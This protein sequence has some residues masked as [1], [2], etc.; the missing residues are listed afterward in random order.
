MSIACLALTML[1]CSKD[2]NKTTLPTITDIAVDNPDFSILV[3]ALTRTN[4]AGTLDD[5]S[6]QF[7]VFAPTNAAFNTFF[8]SLGSGVN[9]NNVNVDVLKAVL[10]NHV[11][12]AEVKAAQ[13]PTAG[14]A[15]TLSPFNATVTNSPGISMFLQK[16]GTNVFINGGTATTGVKVTTADVDA[17]NGVI[18]IVNAVIAIPTI[19]DHVVANPE[20]ETLQTVVTSAPQSAVLNLLAGLTASAPATLFAPNNAAFATALGAGGFANGATDAQVTKVLQYHAS[21]AGNVRSTNLTNNMAI[22]TLTNPA[23]STTA[24]LGNGTVDIRDSANNLARVNQ[25]DIQCSNGVIHGINR[26]LQPVFN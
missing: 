23:Q 6:K 15:T 17:S 13:V 1:A 10:L 14:Y 9:V 16:Q 2:D 19:V 21:A 24:I 11:L 22:P 25:A 20:F 4:L 3:E 8:G 12:G 5:N 7:T 26:V 18:H